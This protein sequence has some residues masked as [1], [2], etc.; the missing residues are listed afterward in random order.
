MAEL[1]DGRRQ[2]MEGELQCQPP[3]AWMEHTCASFKVHNL[4]ARV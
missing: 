3:L 2:E 1:K 4:K